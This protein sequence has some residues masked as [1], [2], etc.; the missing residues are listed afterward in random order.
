MT[1]IHYCSAACFSIEANT[2]G[3]CK[4]MDLARQIPSQRRSM[5]L[6][7]MWLQRGNVHKARLWASVEIY[8]QPCWCILW[9]RVPR[10]G[11]P[12]PCGSHCLALLSADSLVLLYIAAFFG[13]TAFDS[14]L[15][16]AA[17]LGCIFIS[18]RP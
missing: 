16:L 14:T 8:P 5:W 1:Y 3:H 2:Q 13:S 9:G 11:L 12:A 6:H 18:C 4:N 15:C 17:A 7:Y 10:E